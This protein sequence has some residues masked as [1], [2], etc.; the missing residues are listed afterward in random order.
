MKKRGEIM[1]NLKIGMKLIVGFGMVLLMMSILIASSL[2]SLLSINDQV[3]QYADRTIPANNSIW[4]MRRNLV[5]IQRYMLMALAESDPNKISELLNTVSGEGK[6]LTATLDEAAKNPS[7]DA[8]KL[9][10]IKQRMSILSK[11]RAEI[12]ELLLLGTGAAN[13][14]AY[15]LF[16]LDYKPGVDEIAAITEEMG[17][18]QN[19]LATQQRMA[20]VQSFTT[21]LLFIVATSIAA[22]LITIIVI[23]LISRAITRPV[24]E[25]EG[26]MQALSNGDLYNAVV[27]YES[28]DELG[29]LARDIRKTIDRISFL[30]RDMGK[31][32]KE[33]SNGNFDTVSEDDKAYVG[34]FQQLT[35][36]IHGIN[37]RLSETL[38][39]IN[40]ASDQVSSGSDQ[41]SSGAQALSQGATEQA[42]S[43]Q[44]LAATVNEISG[45]VQQNANSAN[46]AGTMSGEATRAMKA[47]N[48]QMQN[49]MGS[50]REIDARSKEIRKIIKTIEDIAFQTNILALNAAVE[51][52]RAGAAGKGFA[53]VA[54]EVR[55]LA[56]KSA[57]AAK[58]TTALIEGSITAID[59]GVS[60]A[61]S[62][63][64]DLMKVVDGA[65]ETTKVILEISQATNEQAEAIAQVTTGLDQISAVVQ[66]NSATAEESAAASQ[67]LSGQALMLKQLVSTF[68]LANVSSLGRNSAGYDRRF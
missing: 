65:Y 61:R 49:L 50:M 47:S 66:T 36:A 8:T 46:R 2:T 10:D 14:Q 26:A 52:A 4:Q 21:A 11:S 22:V 23:T 42:S 13:L 28:Q 33:I 12:S 6:I 7:V 30:I 45:Q 63:A 25:I 34:D 15:K 64:E 9:A 59:T 39:Q 55:S 67:E 31:E 24:K 56:G 62:T 53:V 19:N 35:N 32:L 54:D 3:L 60:L 16:N 27:N 5:S 29:N 17:A 1:K 51:A 58:N 68:R 48:E 20:A 18:T 41:V 57:E 43:V 40:Q 37:M 44:E 38:G